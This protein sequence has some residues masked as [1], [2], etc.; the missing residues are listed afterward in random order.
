MD[1]APIIADG[2][3][4]RASSPDRSRARGPAGLPCAGVGAVEAG[5]RWKISGRPV[6]SVRL[7]G[8]TSAAISPFGPGPKRTSTNWPGRNSVMPNRRNVSM[9]TKI[10]GVPSPRVRKPKPRSRL[11]H[12]TWARSSPLVA[13]TV[14]WVRGGGICAGCTAVDSS[15]DRMRNA[16]RPR[17]RCSTSTTTRAPS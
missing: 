1:G 7:P 3:V 10:S 6:R 9:W 5:W 8:R 16:C 14:T 2:M 13:V 12:F 15:M 4:A 11:N 17:G